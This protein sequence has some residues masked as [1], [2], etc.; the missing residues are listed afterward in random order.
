M[1]EDIDFRPILLDT[2]KSEGGLLVD[3]DGVSNY[4]VRQPIYDSYTKLKKLSPKDVKSLNWGEV[5]DFYKDEFYSKVSDLPTKNLKGVAF[6]F[7]VNA[8][9]RT[10][11]KSLQEV[12]GSKAD[13]IIGKKTIASVN[14]FMEKHGEDALVR[15]ILQKRIDHNYATIANNPQKA[16]YEQGWNNR[17]NHLVE[18]YSK[19]E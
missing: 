17:I 3:E 8:S 12:V 7:A 10:A 11:I 2:L 16:K 6:D 19:Q 4:G 15:S 5:N 1:D 13:G 9:P 14:K 18:T